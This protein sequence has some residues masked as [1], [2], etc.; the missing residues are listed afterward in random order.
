MIEVVGR[1]ADLSLCK[2]YRY[3]LYRELD[4]DEGDTE[5]ITWMMLNPSTADALEDDP[6]IR[7]CMGF[8]ARWGFAHM[9]VINVFAYRAT[10][11]ADMR[12]AIDPH[13]PE[14][15]HWIKKRTD[16]SEVGTVVFAWG[17]H[18]S[19]LDIG[20]RMEKWVKE[21]RKD[22]GCSILGRTKEGHPKHPLYL[23]NHTM[24]LGAGK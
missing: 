12:A 1:D 22:K 11:P 9:Y 13:G 17:T 4:I 3:S 18:G 24:L 14:N 21:L 5:T 16:P 6:T 15:D 2:R 8:S 7:R 19:H 10:S 20:P 23:A